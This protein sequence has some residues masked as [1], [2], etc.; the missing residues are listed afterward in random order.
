MNDLAI[1]AGAY[2]R[3]GSLERIMPEYVRNMDGQTMY[4]S[5]GAVG[6]IRTSRVTRDNFNSM[7]SPD[8]EVL[9]SI[10]ITSEDEKKSELTEF[11]GVLLFKP[12]D[13]VRWRDQIEGIKTKPSMFEVISPLRLES[14]CDYVFYSQRTIKT[15]IR[16]RKRL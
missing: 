15:T 8:E 12:L 11:Y 9:A 16:G 6:M 3:I 10:I 4:R 5:D 1:I 7:G 13:G 14:G 2:G